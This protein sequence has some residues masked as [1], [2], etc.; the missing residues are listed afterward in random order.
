MTI[1]L[2]TCLLRVWYLTKCCQLFGLLY[3][4]LNFY[5]WKSYRSLAR[6]FEISLLPITVDLKADFFLYWFTFVVK[7]FVPDI[8]SCAFAMPVTLLWRLMGCLSSHDLKRGMCIF[9]CSVKCI[10]CSWK[11]GICVWPICA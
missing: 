1:I 6:E 9:S 7:S 8:C 3:V 4:Y 2:N 10:F 5:A 11:F